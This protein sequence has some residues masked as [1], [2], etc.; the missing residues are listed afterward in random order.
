M[1]EI[2]VAIPGFDGA[3]FTFI[4]PLELDLTTPFPQKGFDD[5]GGEIT[6]VDLNAKASKDFSIPNAK[7]VKFGINGG[8][9]AAFGVF[10]SSEKLKAA[11]TK[12]ELNEQL[13]ELLNL[14][15]QENENLFALRWGYDFG[16]SVSGNVGLFSTANPVKLNFGVKA[17]TSGKSYLLH[18]FGRGESVGEA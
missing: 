11:L 9:F 18:S 12:E 3:S 7:K 2:T 5:N 4:S 10:Q 6:L 17:G 16:A 14:K 15:I 13:R 1:N 8:G